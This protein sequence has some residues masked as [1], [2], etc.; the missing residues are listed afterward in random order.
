MDELTPFTRI[1]LFLDKI[2]GGS[3]E[4]PVPQ[5]D[6]ELYLA[7][8]AGESYTLPEPV[9]RWTFYL[10]KIMGQDVALPT[11][12]TRSDL[13]LAAIAGED[14]EIPDFPTTRLEEYLAEWAQGGG[15]LPEEYT[16]L[17]SITFDGDVWYETGEVMTGND[18]VTLTLANTVSTGQNVFGSYNGTTAGAKNFS[19]YL[20]GGGSTS[21]CYLRYGEQLLRPRYGSGKRT[22]TFGKSGTSGFLTDVTATPETFTT[23]AQAYIGMLP[24][25]SSPAYTGTIVGEI[26]VG[27]R[28]QWVPCKR[29]ADGV[30]GYYE[31][32]KRKFIEPSGS[33][34]PT[35]EEI[36]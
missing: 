7:N 35:G 28:L 20:Y 19:L 13:Y 9:S 1:E 17:V 3:N 2:C 36:A 14:V 24:N 30:I 12:Q 22:I 34:T 18:D 8:I 23:D 15:D 21:N 31:M 25:S 32:T 27:T 29:E 33:G 11:P 4:L 10:A 5:T 16:R 6:V 26:H